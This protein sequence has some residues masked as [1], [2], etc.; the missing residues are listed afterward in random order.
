MN[1]EMIVIFCY[2]NINVNSIFSSTVLICA[3]KTYIFV[4]KKR[5]LS[6]LKVGVGSPLSLP[7]Y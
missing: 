3:E 1:S 2:N 4:F 6:V 5:E 7:A